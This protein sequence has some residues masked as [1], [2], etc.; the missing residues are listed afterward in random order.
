MSP[1]PRRSR[2]SYVIEGILTLAAL[3]LL[4]AGVYL[5]WFAAFGR[6]FGEQ[7]VR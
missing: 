6:W 5:G 2:R 1:R 3:A 4:T 7:F